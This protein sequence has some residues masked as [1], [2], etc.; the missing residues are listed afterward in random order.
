[1]PHLPNPSGFPGISGLFAF[2][3]ETGMPMR[4]FVQALLRGPSPLS[5]GERELIATYVSSRNG[6]RFCTR[7]HA[8][9]TRRLGEARVDDVI[10]GKLD[11]VDARMRALLAIAEHVRANVAPVPGALVSAAKEAGADDVAIHDA[12]LIAAAFCMFNRYVDGLGAETPEDGAPAYEAGA[13]RLV[14]Q[15][16]TMQPKT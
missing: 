1:M 13:E 8:A 12:T 15:G 11:G 10:A 16:Y 2:R 14:T 9:V 3:P 4:A 7:S 6:C 5:P